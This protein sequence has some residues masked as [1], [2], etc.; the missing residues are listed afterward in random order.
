MANNTQTSS[1]APRRRQPTKAQIAKA[2]AEVASGQKRP[3]EAAMELVATEGYVQAERDAAAQTRRDLTSKIKEVRRQADGAKERARTAQTRFERTVAL[4]ASE[5][6]EREDWYEYPGA[7]PRKQL[8]EAA[9]L[10]TMTLHRI[11]ERQRKN[12]K[13]TTRRRK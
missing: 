1:A 11:M 13:P 3:S 2:R 4:L 6:P 12:G 10:N 7:L 5:R 8:L 9:G